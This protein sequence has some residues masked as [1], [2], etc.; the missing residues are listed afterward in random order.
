M[1]PA[2]LLPDDAQRLD[3]LLRCN[4]LDTP[5]EPAFD[6]LT[7]LAADLTGAPIALVSLIDADRQWFK[8]RVGLDAEQTPRNQA[9]CGYTIL[10]DEPLVVDDAASDP[11]FADNPLVT[12]APHIRFYAGVPLRL[13]N[14]HAVGTLCVIDTQPRTLTE[15]QLDRLQT[16]AYQASS[17]IEL[18]YRLGELEQAGRAAEH[19]NLAKSMFLANM[20]HEIRT[21]MTAI[22][23]YTDLILDPAS[24]ALHFTDHVATIKRNGEHLIAIINDILDMSKIE[25]G[26]MSVECI[27]TDVVQIVRDVAELMESRAKPKGVE[28]KIEFDADYPERVQTDPTRLRQVLVNLVGNAIKFT[29]SGSITIR[30]TLDEPR[31]KPATLRFAVQDTGL[32]MTPDQVQ[33]ISRF[34]AFSQADESTTRQFG[35]TG[36]GLPICNSLSQMLGG[37]LTIESEPGVGSTF[38][39]TLDPGDLAGVPRIDPSQT[40]AP[41]QAASGVEA[42]GEPLIGLRILLAE[43]GPDNQKLIGLHLRRAGAEVTVADNGLIAVNQLLA[44][45]GEDKPFDLVFMDMQMP[46]LDG[47]SATAQ[48]RQLGYAI[49]VVALT[50]HAMSGDR[51]KC[52]GAG[53]N[54]YLTKPI[55]KAALIDACRRWTQDNLAVAA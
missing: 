44:A 32:G 31:D 34:D 3:A 48:L 54:D 11:R 1:P 14:G 55:A 36:L 43:D 24:S 9:F 40:L 5:A 20:S 2:H 8:S 16:L 53:C 52:L 21:P 39:A 12:G 27:D 38:T 37:Q 23:G 13:S 35:G 42:Q 10:S 25:A 50:A 26:R 46:E 6:D 33:A 18:R 45:A 15:Q 47:Y 29:E 28:L 22:L 30:C 51:Q 7:R 4:L 19:A 17:Q 41:V 49:P